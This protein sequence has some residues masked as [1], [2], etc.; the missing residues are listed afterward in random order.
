[1]NMILGSQF[2]LCCHKESSLKGC[3]NND[4]LT[5]L[6]K[7]ENTVQLNIKIQSAQSRTQ[8]TK[9]Q[10]NSHHH[11]KGDSAVRANSQGTIAAAVQMHRIESTLHMHLC[12]CHSLLKFLSSFFSFYFLKRCFSTPPNIQKLLLNLSSYFLAFWR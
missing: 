12:T 2:H 9:C 8:P 10:R 11:L 7:S 1:M 6:R 3:H 5:C 4:S